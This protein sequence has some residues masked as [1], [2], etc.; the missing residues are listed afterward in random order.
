[1]KMARADLCFICVS[2]FMLVVLICST[3]EMFIDTKITKEDPEPTIQS[4][5]MKSP[6]EYDTS[7]L[8]CANRQVLTL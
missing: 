4:R 2:I 8:H 1:M 7:D 5:G 3:Y 6:N